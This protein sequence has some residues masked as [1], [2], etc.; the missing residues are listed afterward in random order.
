MTGA[1]YVKFS[2][3]INQKYTF[4]TKITNMIMVQNFERISD[5][6]IIPGIC[7]SENFA[8][9]WSIKINK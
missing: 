2:M 5:K 6:F 7:T 1:R 8:Q 3:E 9:K 4:T